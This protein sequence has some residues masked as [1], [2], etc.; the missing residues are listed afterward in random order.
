MDAKE[1]V[2][3]AKRY[4]AYLF[5]DEEI[6]DVGL[7]EIEFDGDVWNVTLGFSRPWSGSLVGGLAAGANAR[8]YRIVRVR[9]S[10]GEVLSVKQRETA[11]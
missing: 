6:K 7:E 8:D 9:A 11:W 10:D 4:V 2:K 5:E 3:A 1:A